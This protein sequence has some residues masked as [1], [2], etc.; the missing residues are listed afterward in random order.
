MG[1]VVCDYPIS[2]SKKCGEKVEYEI[3]ERWRRNES[4]ARSCGTVYFSCPEHVIPNLELK[5]HFRSTILE[6]DIV[7][8]KSGIKPIF[9]SSGGRKLKKNLPKLEEI[10]KQHAF[11]ALKKSIE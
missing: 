3:N 11:E 7:H 9:S 5:R 8:L 4:W 1:M 6:V 10:L 2:E